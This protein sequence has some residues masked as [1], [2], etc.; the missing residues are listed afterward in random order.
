MHHSCNT[1]ESHLFHMLVRMSFSNVLNVRDYFFISSILKGIHVYATN[2]CGILVFAT[3]I[4]GILSISFGQYPHLFSENPSRMSMPQSFEAYW[5]CRK[6]LRHTC[7]CRK[8]LRHTQVCHKYLWHTRV[9]L[10]YLPLR[11]EGMKKIM[12]YVGFDGY[13]IS[14]NK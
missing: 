13:L 1:L 4:C 10:V 8:Y 6:Y 3:D 9:W 14:N 5:V 2:V 12:S 7:V 11:M